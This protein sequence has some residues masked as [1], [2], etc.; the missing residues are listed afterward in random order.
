MGATPAPMNEGVDR[1]GTGL[2]HA[3]AD[4]DA[5]PPASRLRPRSKG[6]SEIETGSPRVVYALRRRKRA[7]DAPATTEG[8]AH[9]WTRPVCHLM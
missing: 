2:E 8:E 7:T 4:A 9:S 3:P 1:A 5:R 6:L